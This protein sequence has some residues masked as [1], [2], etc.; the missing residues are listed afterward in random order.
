MEMLLASSSIGQATNRPTDRPNS[1]RR[2]PRRVCVWG[3]ECQML[4][5]ELCVHCVRAPWGKGTE[6]DIRLI[7]S[8]PTENDRVPSSFYFKKSPL[9]VYVTYVRTNVRVSWHWA[10]GALKI[11]AKVGTKTT[12]QTDREREKKKNLFK[13]F[14]LEL[15][16]KS[17]LVFSF[18]LFFSVTGYVS[19]HLVNRVGMGDDRVAALA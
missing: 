5:T 10:D 15:R 9:C 19:F 13:L 2:E 6:D 12:R 11:K 8:C 16:G 18:F 14:S 7:R 1:R 17:D 3:K 4:A